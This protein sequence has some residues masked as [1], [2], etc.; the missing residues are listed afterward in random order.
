MHIVHLV[1]DDSSMGEWMYLTV[2]ALRGLGSISA[3]GG[4]FKR[5]FLGWSH[6]ANLALHNLWTSFKHGQTMTEKNMSKVAPKTS[7]SEEP[8]HFFN[9]LPS[10]ILTVYQLQ[11]RVEPHERVC[12]TTPPYSETCFCLDLGFAR[13]VHTYSGARRYWDLNPVSHVVTPSLYHWAFPLFFQFQVSRSFGEDPLPDGLQ[14]EL[15]VGYGDQSNTSVMTVPNDGIVPVR[16]IPPELNSFSLSMQVW[17]TTVFIKHSHRLRSVSV[18][19][20]P[21]QVATGCHHPV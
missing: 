14:V 1:S 20:P 8:S 16:L 5:S 11:L 10:Q 18:H 9:W 3:H 6:S 21:R 12:I 17:Q 4:Y 2:C 13:G 15:S 19:T 7:V